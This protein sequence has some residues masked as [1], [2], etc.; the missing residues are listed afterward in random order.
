MVVKTRHNRLTGLQCDE[1]HPV[2]G[3]CKH[4]SLECCYDDSL[5]FVDERARLERRLA[6]NQVRDK[7]SR[8]QLNFQLKFSI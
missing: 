2:C 3:Q 1:Q 6:T 7:V 4:L 5:R 8:T